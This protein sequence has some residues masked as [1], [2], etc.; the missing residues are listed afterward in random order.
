MKKTKYQRIKYWLFEIFCFMKTYYD[1]LS[2]SVDTTSDGMIYLT[3]EHTTIG[4]IPATS[5]FSFMQYRKAVFVEKK[6][7]YKPTE[8][9]LLGL[10]NRFHY[11]NNLRNVHIIITDQSSIVQLINYDRNS[12]LKNAGVDQE[13]AIEQLIVSGSRTPGSTTAKFY[14]P[15]LVS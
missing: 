5:K 1:A 2:N 10:C 15:I 12:G 9:K 6:K 4:L 3:C 8:K 11:N 7:Y 14:F 13:Y